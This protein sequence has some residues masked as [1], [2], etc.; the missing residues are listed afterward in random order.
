MHFFGR[1]L[2]III[3]ATLVVVA[4]SFVISNESTISLSLWPFTQNLEIPIWLFGVGAF[5][6]GGILGAVLME[7]QLLAI[8]I[9]LWRAQSQIKKLDKQFAQVPEKDTNQALPH[10]PDL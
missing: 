5:V 2:W 4:I 6:T 8:R 9:K 10:T 1:L 3:T 7:G